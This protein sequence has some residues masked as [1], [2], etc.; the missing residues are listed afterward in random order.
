MCIRDRDRVVEGGDQDIG[1][2]QHA[3]GA[4]GE[5]GEHRDGRWPVVVDDRV[6]LLHPDGVEA[7]ILAAD[8]FLEGFLVI[9]PAFDGDEADLQP[10]HD[11]PFTGEW[12]GRA[13]GPGESISDSRRG[14]R[15][16]PTDQ[17]TPARKRDPT[18]GPGSGSVCRYLQS[19]KSFV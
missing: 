19:K 14:R 17:Y 8:H 15:R 2:E 5:A 13:L 9:L 10:R 16:W 18:S 7:E 12:P 4:G 3:G 6:M 11:H 1:A